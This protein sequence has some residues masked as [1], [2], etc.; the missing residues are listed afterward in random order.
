VLLAAVEKKV[1]E[2]GK[3]YKTWRADLALVKTAMRM[4]SGKA[5]LDRMG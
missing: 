5:F 2:Q 4:G 1:D 3:S